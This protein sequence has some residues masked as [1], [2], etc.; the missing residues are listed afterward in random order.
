MKKLINLGLMLSALLAQTAFAETNIVIHSNKTGPSINKNIYGQ[1]AEHLGKGMYGGLWVGPD[2]KI[3]NTRGWR[4]D[5]LEALKELNVPVLRWPG[6]CFAD[7]YHWQDGIGKPDKRPVTLNTLWG[8]VEESNAVGTH[9]FFDLA[10]L[11][12]AETFVNGN[13]GTGSPQEMSAWI[14]YMTSDSQSE[15]AKLR[16]ENGRDKPFRVD[17]FGIGNEAWGCGGGMSPEYY[18]NLYRQWSTFLRPPWGVKINWVASGGHGYGDAINKDGLTQWTD[19]LTSNIEADFLLG[20]DAV[21]FHYYTHPKGSV[22]SDKGPAIGF[23]ESEWISTLHNTLKMDGFIEKNKAVM[24][25]NDPENKIALYIDEWGTWYNNTENT[26]PA[27]MI[28]VSSQRDAVVAALNFNIFHKYAERVKMTNIAQ[29]VNVLQSMVVTDK[30]R[31][32]LTPTYHVYKMYVPFHNAKRVP[33]DIDNDPQYKHSKLSID[34]ISASAARD[35]KGQ[36]HLALV[37]TDPNMKQRITVRLGD[38]KISHAKGQ[39]LASDSM[40]AHNTFEQADR[41]STKTIVLMVEDDVI[42]LDLPPAGVSVLTI[43]P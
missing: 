12:G 33:I 35:D 16:R 42:T 28:Q 23:P 39:L 21:G 24:D 27:F 6:G 20:F 36:I 13:L 14:E 41:V 18:T 10:N 8:G 38:A 25:K 22:M 7:E 37:N 30:E 32:L 26:N 9:E 15:L 31:M 1:F 5:V 17:H 29:M 34:A 43:T 19:Y 3:A 4:N 40:D 11:L 2:S